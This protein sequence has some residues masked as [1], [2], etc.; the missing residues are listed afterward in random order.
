MLN[1]GVYLKESLSRSNVKLRCTVCGLSFMVISELLQ[2]KEKNSEC[3]NNMNIVNN[4]LDEQDIENE[5]KTETAGLSHDK[6]E[7]INEQDSNDN[8]L[9][10]SQDEEEFDEMNASELEV[11]ESDE[12]FN[13]EYLDEGDLNLEETGSSSD[14][15][16]VDSDKIK[17]NRR[18]KN[19]C[20][21]DV[22]KVAKKKRKKKN[23]DDVPKPRRKY[24]KTF[25]ETSFN[26]ESKPFYLY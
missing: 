26:C 4:S 13:D 14:P 12:E 19:R 18:K 23:E 8:N 20:L 3:L 25:P 11:G 9:D 5:N 22:G 15:E 21:N 24:T 2:H 1:C 16:L 6:D 7:F 17:T 10:Y